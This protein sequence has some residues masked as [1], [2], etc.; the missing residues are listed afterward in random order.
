MHEFY[1]LLLYLF[2]ILNPQHIDLISYHCILVFQFIALLSPNL[3][4]LGLSQ[5]WYVTF[6]CFC[7]IFFF[8]IL[9]LT[10]IRGYMIIEKGLKLKSHNT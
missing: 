10:N 1:M 2:Q 6:K 3:N 8:Q 5:F 9:I 4:F 7:M